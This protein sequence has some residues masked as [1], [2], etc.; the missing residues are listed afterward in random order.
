MGDEDDDG[1]RESKDATA[2][3]TNKTS[4]SRRSFVVGGAF[5]FRAG[6][7]EKL[8]EEA[9]TSRDRTFQILFSLSIFA[10]FLFCV[11]FSSFL[12]AP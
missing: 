6:I 8:K 1:Q 4:S 11:F 7:N 10:F 3:A 2:M 9:L 5:L 12:S